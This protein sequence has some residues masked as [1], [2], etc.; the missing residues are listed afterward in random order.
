MLK[1][2]INNWYLLQHKPN[3]Q[4]IALDNLERQGFETFY[5]LFEHLY[6]ELKKNY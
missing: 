1:N 4:K 2:N 3:K 6:F 5:P